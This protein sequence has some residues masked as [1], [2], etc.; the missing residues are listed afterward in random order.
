MGRKTRDFKSFAAGCW[1]IQLEKDLAKLLRRD[2]ALR[3]PGLLIGIRLAAKGIA[4]AV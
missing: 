4:V 1:L 3:F 2:A